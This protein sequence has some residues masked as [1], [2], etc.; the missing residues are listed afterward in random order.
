MSIDNSSK[1]TP[2][3]NANNLIGSSSAGG[4]SL[5]QLDNRYLKLGSSQIV[6]EIIN[7]SLQVNSGET[8]LGNVTLGSTSN[9]SVKLNGSCQIGV[10][11]N[12]IDAID[13][14]NS[15]ITFNKLPTFS[16]DFTS[17]MT[18]SNSFVS[19][20]YVDTQISSIS[21]SQ[22]PSGLQGP[23]GSIGRTGPTGPIG[24]TGFTG[25]MGP[26]G[27]TGPSGLQGPTGTSGAS[28]LGLSNTFSGALNTFT[29]DTIAYGNSQTVG[30]ISCNGNLSVDHNIGFGG[31]INS[32]PA[33]TL[34]YISNVTSDIQ[35]QINSISLIKGATGPTGPLGPL[36]PTGQIGPTGFTGP[37]G[38]TGFTGPTGQIGPTGP[39]GSAI[40]NSSNT[41]SSNNVFS[42]LPTSTQTC[43]NDNQFVIKS[44]VDGCIA[45]ITQNK[46]A[47][48]S[49]TTAYTGNI[50]ST[51]TLSPPT[52]TGATHTFVLN[53]PT[54]SNSAF[55]FYETQIQID[56]IINS[57]YPYTGGVAKIFPNLSTISSCVYNL[58]INNNG[59]NIGKGYFKNISAST[60]TST[61][62]ISNAPNSSD[63]STIALPLS[64]I[65][66]YYNNSTNTYTPIVS[67]TSSPSY[68]NQITITFGTPTSTQNYSTSNW[69]GLLN[70]S[71]KILGG[72]YGF[73]TT[74][75]STTDSSSDTPYFTFIQ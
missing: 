43:T 19:K 58:R 61:W 68:P 56:F 10:D 73:N 60:S 48:I 27:F 1:I 32:I 21:L 42:V 6:N 49:Y 52:L 25:P 24:P 35:N 40:L 3:F 50:G 30:N 29:H 7:G 59:N 75:Y 62:A 26:T 63:S 70:T 12:G 54:S 71:C 45:S 39:S 8:V 2:I 13:I 22:G 64:S 15:A 69:I 31:T 9:S 67:F 65:N 17:S 14:T 72:T 51:L 41:W 46:I 4:Y 74:T 11:G 38:P 47:S 53:F 5:G 36:G 66:T 23:T 34:G 20:K 16:S 33:S 57:F 44:Y 18:N 55:L 28:I 37:I